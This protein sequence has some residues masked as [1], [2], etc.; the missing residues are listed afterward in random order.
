MWTP[1]LGQILVFKTRPYPV[2]HLDKKLKSRPGFQTQNHSPDPGF[3]VS[4]W[5]GFSGCPAVEK[6]I[7]E[8]GKIAIIQEI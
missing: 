2:L 5:V 1:N 4:D 7:G 6:R 3:S 8:K